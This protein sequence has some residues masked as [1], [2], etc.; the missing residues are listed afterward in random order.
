MLQS[1][2]LCYDIL[3][4]ISLLRNIH[5]ILER[6]NFISKCCVIG[7][8]YNINW[9]TVFS[10]KSIMRVRRLCWTCRNKKMREFRQSHSLMHIS[11]TKTSLV[12][13]LHERNC[14]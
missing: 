5:D 11:K 6:G 10:P 13:M 2:V 12:T 9:V 3:I 7:K 8:I 4:T 1:Q 14:N